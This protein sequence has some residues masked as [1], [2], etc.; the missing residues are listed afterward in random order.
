MFMSIDR[1]SLLTYAA[2][3]P[4]AGALP[5]TAHT[6]EANVTEKADY[7]V[8]IATGLVELSPEH[9][10]STTL[11]NRQFPGPLIRLKE[12]KR[13]VVDIYN[14]TDTPELLHWHG[15]FVPTDVDGALEEGTPPVAPHDMRPH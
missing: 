7:T 11:Y 5:R 10:V 6:A 3:L 15:Q 4:L 13:V 12:G 8:R 9:I 14:D 1:R 2:A